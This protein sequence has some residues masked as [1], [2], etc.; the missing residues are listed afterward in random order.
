MIHEVIQT[1]SRSWSTFWMP[2][3]FAL[4]PGRDFSLRV[5]ASIAALTIVMRLLRVTAKHSKLITNYG[6]VA[7]K[8]NENGL[9][10]DEWDFIIVGGGSIGYSLRIQSC[11]L[12]RFL[13]HLGTAGCVL[14]S[15]LS[16]DP[17]LR[18]LL[19]EAG[20]RSA[21]RKVS[22]A[23][24]MLRFCVALKMS[25]KAGYPLRSRIY[26]ALVGTTIFI[27]SPSCMQATRKN[28][29]RVVGHINKL[30]SCEIE[31]C[32]PSETPRRM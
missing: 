21:S 24:E 12:V 14:A 18:V 13:I 6:K 22:F 23:P 28:I 2:S 31:S 5:A 32:S 3:N 16:E 1:R 9:E 30:L 20:G 26:S 7:R 11:L 4:A 8:V 27:Q 17:N 19:I 15:R 25:L 10:F 29:G